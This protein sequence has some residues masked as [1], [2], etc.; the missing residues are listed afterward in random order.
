[1]SLL[2]ASMEMGWGVED[3][4]TYEALVEEKLNED[5]GGEAFEKYEILNH[6]VAGYYPL[7]QAVALEKALQFGPRTVLYVATGREFSRSVYYLSEVVS[8]GIEIPY[9]ELGAIAAAAGLESK[10]PQEEA[11]RRL[12]PHRE[13]LLAWLYEHIVETCRARGAS[14]VWVFVPQ[15]HQGSW[16]EETAPARALAKEKGFVVQIDLGDVFEGL[17]PA[18]HQ[19]AEWDSHPNARGHAVIAGRLYSAIRENEV[20]LGL[21]DPGETAKP[22]A[23]ELA[24]MELEPLKSQVKDYILREFLPGESSEALSYST[25]LIS[26][27]IL[28]SIATLKLVSFLED[29]FGIALEAHDVDAEHLDTIEKIADLVKARKSAE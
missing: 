24:R 23:K 12:N 7:Q 5:L 6:A 29:R 16:E 28:D 20:V 4:E 27:G 21:L 9:P 11:S 2:G 15:I 18:E 8:K 10:M 3:G 17:D 1:M 26:G 22:E 19:L 25:P 14:P 13:E